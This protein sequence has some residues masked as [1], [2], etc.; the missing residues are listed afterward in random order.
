MHGSIDHG[1][2]LHKKLLFK[3]ERRACIGGRLQRHLLWT[4]V[5]LLQVLR[6][7]SRMIRTMS[8]GEALKHNSAAKC[9]VA[10]RLLEAMLWK[11]SS[12]ANRF[13]IRNNKVL[14]CRV[15]PSSLFASERTDPTL[16]ACCLGHG[17]PHSLD[18]TDSK[19]ACRFPVGFPALGPWKRVPKAPS[20][21][22]WAR[23]PWQF[24]NDHPVSL[25]KPTGPL[26]G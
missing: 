4:G 16:F 12:L 23:G 10:I 5:R 15:T 18:P 26:Q 20:F 7:Q 13:F 1:M 21:I 9:N 14:S 11:V 3:V 22:G 17:A 6:T 19:P 24:R 8:S 25:V 2:A